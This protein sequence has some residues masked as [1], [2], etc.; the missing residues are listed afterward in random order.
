MAIPQPSLFS[1]QDIEV[2]TDIERF[3]LVRDNMPDKKIIQYLE[4][5]RGNGR[6]DF[7]I[8]AMWNALLDFTRL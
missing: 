2:K 1:W 6:D 4:V 8:I 7:P 3:I 5:M